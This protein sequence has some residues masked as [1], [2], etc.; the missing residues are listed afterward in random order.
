[1]RHAVEIVVVPAA[2]EDDVYIIRRAHGRRRTYW[3]REPDLFRYLAHQQWR[4]AGG[5]KRVE[6]RGRRVGTRSHLRVVR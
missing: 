5:L 4:T 2:S 3:A 1:C 6:R